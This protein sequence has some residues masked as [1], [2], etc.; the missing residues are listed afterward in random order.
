MNDDGSQP[1]CFFT[2]SAKG[3]LTDKDDV[4][5]DVLDPITAT[6]S[7]GGRLA[8][9]SWNALSTYRFSDLVTF[10]SL[11]YR[12][13]VT[14]SQG[15]QPLTSPEDWTQVKLNR[16]WNTEE[17]YLINDI[18]QEPT[19]GSLYSAITD[20]S[21]QNPL[22]FKADWKP[23]SSQVYSAVE[24]YVIGE[25]VSDDVGLMWRSLV[26]ANINNTPIS[27]PS[28]WAPVVAGGVSDVQTFTSSGTWTKPP[29]GVYAIVEEVGGGGGGANQTGGG[30][31]PGGGGGGAYAIRIFL[32]SDLG[33]T[34]TVTIGAGGLGGADGFNDV[35]SDGSDTTFGSF[36]TAGGGKRPVG[37]VNRGGFG[38]GGEPGASSVVSFPLPVGG[39]SSGGGHFGGKGADCVMGG[40]GGGGSPA[41]AGGISQ[42]GGDG[43][44]ANSTASTKGGNGVAPGGGGGASTNDGGG[45][46][47][48]A[49][50][51]VVTVI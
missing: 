43:G 47:G 32:L 39:F 24:T 38:G 16:V 41:F 49:G 7:E 26:D 17:S 44:T 3:I 19:T 30:V 40:G 9:A 10:N 29:S 21:A 2:G 22:T 12:S 36:L 28:Q 42:N 48:A 34:E 20:N 31:T 14:T 37:S 50:E 6:A 27:S 18:V 11:Y 1:P 35:G 51:C 4:Q 8:F 15:Q 5:I 46:D 23:L 45:G 33:S 13:H 25:V